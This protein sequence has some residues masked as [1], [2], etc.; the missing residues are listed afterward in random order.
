M[1]PRG[2]ASTDDSWTIH[3]TLQLQG[4]GHRRAVPLQNVESLGIF[5]YK[6]YSVSKGYS[7]T[8]NSGSKDI[9]VQN[10]SVSKEISL[11]NISF[12]KDIPVHTF[13][14]N[15]FGLTR[16]RNRGAQILQRQVVQGLFNPRAMLGTVCV[17]PQRE[18]LESTDN[19]AHG[20]IGVGGPV[21][22]KIRGEVNVAREPC[23]STK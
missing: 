22:G 18:Q 8:T 6:K 13:V 2:P 5:Q 3:R 15:M 16:Q 4:W 17:R 14:Q 20:R 11:R 1:P 23:P 9:R 12:S 19:A 7:S 21:A 10:I